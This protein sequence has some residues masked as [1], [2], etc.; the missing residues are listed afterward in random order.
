MNILKVIP[1]LR[2]VF[3]IKSANKHVVKFKIKKKFDQDVK[4]LEKKDER[5]QRCVRLG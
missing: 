3:Y 5:M 4:D 2:Y 1:N